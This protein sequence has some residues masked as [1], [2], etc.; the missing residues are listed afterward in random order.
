MRLCLL[1]R[2]VFVIAHRISTVKSAD[3]VVVLEEG[4]VAQVGTHDQLL[5]QPGHYR[6]IVNLQLYGD[7]GED[8]EERLSHMD[9]M[10]Q[11]YEG[12]GLVPQAEPQPQEEGV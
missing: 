5:A 7:D 12:R 10:R 8:G 9:R 6:Q 3:V 1:D 2:T 4:R 11:F